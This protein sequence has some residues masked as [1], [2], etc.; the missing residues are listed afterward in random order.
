MR[1]QLKDF[2][3]EGV[4]IAF[5]RNMFQVFKTVYLEFN[6]AVDSN[7]RG[8]SF[9]EQSLTDDV[10]IIAFLQPL[11][12][13]CVQSAICISCAMLSDHIQNGEIR[14]VQCQYLTRQIEKANKDFHVPVVVGLSAHDN[15]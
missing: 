5:K 4:M 7:D 11:H 8:S 13:D 2:H 15:P 1:T 12:Q 6:D 9:K 10:A 3:Y 14:M